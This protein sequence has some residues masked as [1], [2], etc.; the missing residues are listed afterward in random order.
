MVLEAGGYAK[1]LE[2]RYEASWAAYQLLRL[3]EEKLISIIVE[4]ICED[5]VGVDQ[6]RMR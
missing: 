5:E 6:V 2:N 1:K 4:P 3:L